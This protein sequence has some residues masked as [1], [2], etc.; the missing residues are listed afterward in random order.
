MRVHKVGG[1]FLETGGISLLFFRRKAPLLDIVMDA[2]HAQCERA[3]IQRSPD[4]A[5]AFE[6]DERNRVPA[7]RDGESAAGGRDDEGPGD[8]R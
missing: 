8:D 3:P 2:L 7:L 1:R 5:D 4:I 6:G